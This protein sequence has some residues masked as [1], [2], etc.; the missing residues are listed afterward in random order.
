[1]LGPTRPLPTLGAQ[2]R[3]SHFGGEVEMG[4]VCAVRDGGRHVEVS[5]ESGE[6]FEFLLHPA[7]AK[8]VISG[9]AHGME[10]ELLPGV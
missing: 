6:R 8:F 1:M 5:V 3:I 4:V 2:A 7:T 10:M 9:A